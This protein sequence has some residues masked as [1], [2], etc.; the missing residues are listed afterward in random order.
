MQWLFALGVVTV[1]LIP[2][3]LLRNFANR[4]NKE[5]WVYFL[6]GLFIGF[7]GFELGKLVAHVLKP[8]IER[9]S[10]RYLGIFMFVVAYSFT[11]LAVRVVRN[12]IEKG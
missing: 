7:L 2:A 6:V 5:G 4:N 10:E 11:Y 1:F 12:R 9:E 8:M 3:F